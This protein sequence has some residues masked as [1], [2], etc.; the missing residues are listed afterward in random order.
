MV[1]DRYVAF[2][3]LSSLKWVY[4]TCSLNAEI[5]FVSPSKFVFVKHPLTLPSHVNGVN[6]KIGNAFLANP[7][8]VDAEC[9]RSQSLNQKTAVLV[10]TT[11]HPQWQRRRLPHSDRITCRHILSLLAR[12][13]RHIIHPTIMRTTHRRHGKVQW[14][15]ILASP[16]VARR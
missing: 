8:V 11:I 16:K 9:A 2:F 13:R 3:I 1:E 4:A 6:E 15:P 14:V 5:E 7:I 10:R 12:T